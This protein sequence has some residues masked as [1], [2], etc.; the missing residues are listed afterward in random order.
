MKPL[1]LLPL[2]LIACGDSDDAKPNSNGTGTLDTG[3]P[4]DGDPADADDTAASD[5]TAT[6]DDTGDTEPPEPASDPSI[7]VLEV[8]QS[9]ADWRD[10]AYLA[11]IPAS[12]QANGGSPAV[13]AL[14]DA[15][16]PSA[17]VGDLLDR[18]SPENGY[19]IG[20]TPSVPGAETVT[21]FDAD[22]AQ[23]WSL[24]LA[25]AF[26]DDAA[27]AVVVSDSD[28]AGAVFGA[29]L[30]AW[31]DAPLLIDDASD[32]A[33]TQDAISALEAQAIVIG[34]DGE[35]VALG[36][37]HTALSGLDAALE[38]VAARGE[39]VTYLTVSNPNDRTAGRSQK[40]SLVAP[41]YAANR[42]GLSLPVAIGMPTA[43]IEDGADH[44][45]LPSLMAAYDTLGAPP[46]HLAIVGG[47]DALPMMRKP[48]IF[49][50]PLDEQPV[51]D[52][53]YGQ[54]DLDA[55][56]D[57]AIGR[58]VGHNLQEMS[59]TASRTAQYDRLRDGNWDTQFMEAGLW[60]FD[61]L[62]SMTLNVGFEPPEHF[63][64]ADIAASSSLEV[65]AFL[66]KDHSYCQV[67]GHAMDVNS[68]ALLAPAV[69]MSRGCSVGGIDMLRDDQPS[70]TEHMFA[71]GAVAFVGAARNAIA[72]NT[73]I[74]V[75]L[76]NQLL[77][78][79]TLGQSFR[80]GVNDA[81]VHWLDEGSSAMRYAI[82]TEI[83]FGDPAFRIHVPATHET[84]PAA[85]HFDGTTLSVT[86]PEEWTLVAYH[87]EMLAEWGFGGDLFMYTAPGAIPSTYWAGS[88]DNEDMYFGVQLPLD[89][90]PFT[91]EEMGD[92]PSPLGWGGGV[93]I[94]EHPDGSASALWRVRLLDF[95]AETGVITAEESEFTYRVD[96]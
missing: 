47:H 82:D 95:D 58:V 16:D 3:T 6:A 66:H 62:R 70:I 43:L 45:V 57:I 90:P 25:N 73:I 93:H 10:F 7:F 60:G 1:F 84:E 77:A 89:A 50:N 13:L 24:A 5:D 42:G 78:G 28:Y 55:F 32:T 86:A 96:G 85:Q 36:I 71:Q 64:E 21:G 8:S 29:S 46:E 34:I 12:A 92:Y 18:L 69:V 35:P 61:E 67:L 38:W 81:M 83:V 39:P 27:H 91:V 14:A 15:S 31:L 74:E 87:P 44:P 53:P 76:W 65:S 37:E 26:W 54:A 80:H 63:S 59:T 72:H 2:L 48:S 49:D 56:L 22:G 88:H 11:A 41:M 23:A 19:G 75:S 68:T 20:G 4:N 52:L 30:A 33:A 17:P 94:D 40:A 9:D 79:H 51:S